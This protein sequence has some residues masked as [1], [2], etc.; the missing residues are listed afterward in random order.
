MNVF[1]KSKWKEK[2]LLSLPLHAPPFPP[3]SPVTTGPGEAS[4]ALGCPDN[5]DKWASEGL[6]QT[7]SERGRAGLLK[8]SSLVQQ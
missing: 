8:V 1:S 2:E 6:S 5:L 7:T 4:S 3:A